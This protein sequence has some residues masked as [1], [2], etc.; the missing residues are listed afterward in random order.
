MPPASTGASA[1]VL[2]AAVPSSAASSPTAPDRLAPGGPG[3][4][5]MSFALFVAG[6]ATFALLYSTQALLPA[7]SASFHATAEQASWTVSAATG[8]LALCVLP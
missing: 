5:R 7:V 4:R 8:G 1:I 3:Y 2:D 6:I